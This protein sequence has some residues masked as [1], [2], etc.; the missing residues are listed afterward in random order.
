MINVAVGK[1]D[2]VVNELKTID[3]IARISSVTG[4]RDF[5]VVVEVGSLAEL[6]DVI[7]EIHAV[8]YIIETETQVVMREL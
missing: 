3:N 6:N 4:T 2:E 5:V 8:S 1:S 7:S